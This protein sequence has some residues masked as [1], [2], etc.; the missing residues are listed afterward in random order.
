MQQDTK[1]HKFGIG[2]KGKQQQSYRRE[3]G[4]RQTSESRLVLLQIWLTF[5]E[6]HLK[7]ENL[8]VTQF[9]LFVRWKQTS[10]SGAVKLFLVLSKEIHVSW[11]LFNCFMQWMASSTSWQWPSDEVLWKPSQCHTK[12]EF[13]HSTSTDARVGFSYR[14]LGWSPQG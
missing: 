6:T 12:A 13:S 10:C 14:V 11:E 7:N 8:T 5:Q 2:A 1:K 3:P 9:T 4:R